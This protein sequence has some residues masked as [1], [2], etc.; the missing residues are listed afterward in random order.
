MTDQNPIEP[1]RAKWLHEMMRDDAHREH[2]R[3][4]SFFEQMNDSSIKSSQIVFRACL[5]INGGAAVSVLAFIGG[6]A[7]KELVGVSQFKPAADSLVP[8]AFGVWPPFLAW[9]YRML[10]Y[11]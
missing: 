8:F 7:S 10:L 11:M 6:L 4:N 5:L 2:D 1:D 9:D 3:A